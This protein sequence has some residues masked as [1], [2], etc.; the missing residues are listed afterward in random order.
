MKGKLWAV[1]R[2]RSSFLPACRQRVSSRSTDEP[3]KNTFLSLKVAPPENR[4]CAS[5]IG[6]PA[7]GEL[8]R[9]VCLWYCASRESRLD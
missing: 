7:V 5:D 1:A 9:D 4:L 3:I 2:R 6:I 8:H